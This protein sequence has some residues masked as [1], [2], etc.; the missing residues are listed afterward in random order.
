MVVFGYLVVHD[1]LCSP[2]QLK[3]VCVLCL[4][5]LYHVVFLSMPFN[6]LQKCFE[7]LCE[8]VL[9]TAVGK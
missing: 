4:V 6:A 2:I 7:V 8:Y 9:L 3:S 1:G 5:V